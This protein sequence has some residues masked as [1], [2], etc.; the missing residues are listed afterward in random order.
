MGVMRKLG[1]QIERNPFS[2][3]PWMQVVGFIALLRAPDSPV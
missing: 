1:M 3:P 2:D